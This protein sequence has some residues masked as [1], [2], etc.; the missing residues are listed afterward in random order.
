MT[1]SKTTSRNPE[2]AAK[3]ATASPEVLHTAYEIHTLAQMVRGQIATSY[4]WVAPMFAPNSL[5]PLAAWMP[6]MAGAAPTWAGH[7]PWSW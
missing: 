6:P 1:T 5:E 4:P 7:T 2:P 3:E